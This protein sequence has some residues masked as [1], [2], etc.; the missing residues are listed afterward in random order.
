[1]GPTGM[2]LAEA[3]LGI[4]QSCILADIVVHCSGFM[5]FIV[6]FTLCFPTFPH[7]NV[8]KSHPF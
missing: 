3:Q 4:M 5:Q 2:Q 6:L 8:M 7:L 1:M